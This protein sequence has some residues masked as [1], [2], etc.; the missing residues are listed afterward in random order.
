MYR[1]FFVQRAEVIRRWRTQVVEVRDLLAANGAMQRPRWAARWRKRLRIPVLSILALPRRCRCSSMRPGATRRSP[2]R[3]FP[4]SNAS[5]TLPKDRD[6]GSVASSAGHIGPRGRCL[7]ANRRAAAGH[8]VATSRRRPG[9][10]VLPSTGGH[11]GACRHAW[12][13]CG[14]RQSSPDRRPEARRRKANAQDEESQLPEYLLLRYFDFDV[15]PNKQYQ[16]RIFLVLDNPNYRLDD[17]VLEDPDCADVECLGVLGDEAG[18]ER[19]RRDL[20]WPTDPK[21]AK[22]SQPCISG[23]VSGRHA[24]AGWKGP[25]RQESPGDQRGGAR[26]AM[27]GEVRTKRQFLAKRTWSAAPSSTS[28]MQRSGC[29]G[30]GKTT[31]D[32][33][34]TNCI[35]VDI[36]GGE[37]LATAKDKSPGMILVMDESGNLVVHD[38]VAEARNG[39]RRPRSRKG[40]GDHATRS[41]GPAAAAPRGGPDTTDIEIGPGGKSTPTE[42]DG[43]VGFAVGWAELGVVPSCRRC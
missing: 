32:P 24:A 13:R 30:A 2:R 11:D 23:R 22:W 21:Y 43:R 31:Q 20:D 33:L 27:A 39:K 42:S 18:K 10:L 26:P 12:Q 4:L 41:R 16:Y 6:G 14:R 37:P 35:L 34:T 17:D 28:R 7:A 8:P 19:R 38:E 3:R 1:G 5:R 40:S 25:R 36:Q 15:K 9:V 29:P